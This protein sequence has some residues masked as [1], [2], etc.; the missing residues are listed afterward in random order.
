MSPGEIDNLRRLLSDLLK[1]IPA[2]PVALDSE[3][4]PRATRMLMSEIVLAIGRLERLRDSLD[5]IRW[6][7]FVFDPS[8]PKFVGELVGK[9]LVEQP[10]QPLAALHRFYGSGVY[11]IYY[12]GNFPP[13]RPI[14]GRKT[15]IYVGKADPPTPDAKNAKEQ[16]TKLWARLADHAKSIRSTQNLNIN[17]FQCRYLVVQSGWQKSAEDYL[18]HRFS[19]IWNQST[20]FGFGKH[21]DAPSTRGNTRSPW[22]TLHP[23]RP[24]A[25]RDGNK[26]NPLTPEKLIEKI[27]EHYRQNPPG[28]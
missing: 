9:T 23:G 18:I 28:A 12:T 14:V 2:P 5:P 1:A 6:P 10:T 25:T 7:D 3:V 21:G 17:D 11:A 16:G 19:P 26:V 27:A 24:W 4:P 8:N 20:C 13:Y 15:P 22:D